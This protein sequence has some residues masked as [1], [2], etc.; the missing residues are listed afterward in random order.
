VPNVEEFEAYIENM[1]S[2]IIDV[3]YWFVYIYSYISCHL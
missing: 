1:A 2:Y 3:H